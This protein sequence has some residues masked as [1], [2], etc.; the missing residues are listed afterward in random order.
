M[1]LERPVK[2]EEVLSETKGKDYDCDIIETQQ[3][4]KAV[5]DFLFQGDLLC[6][7]EQNPSVPSKH[8]G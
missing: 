5:H 4:G 1:L 6:A 2:I 7:T 8:A 3:G